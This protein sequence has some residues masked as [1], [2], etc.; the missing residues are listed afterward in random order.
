MAVFIRYLEDLVE[1]E[2]GVIHSPKLILS[3]TLGLIIYS[4]IRYATQ[5]N[6]LA[7]QSLVGYEFVSWASGVIENCRCKPI[8]KLCLK[9]SGVYYILLVV[10]PV[11]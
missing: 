9:R 8:C 6:S 1:L 7:A 5:S 10:L 3:S 4:K 11:V 2:A